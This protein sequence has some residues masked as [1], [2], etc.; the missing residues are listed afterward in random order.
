MR[1]LKKIA[2]FI[3]ALGMI[4]KKATVAFFGIVKK[5]NIEDMAIKASGTAVRWSSYYFL[6]WGIWFF[7]GV[8]VGILKYYKAPEVATFLTLW[9]V[10]I[11]LAIV[12]IVICN[13]TKKD[14]TLGEAIRNS[15]NAVWSESR[16]VGA[17]VFIG[18]MIKFIFWDGSDRVLIFFNKE[19][20]TFEKK[21]FLLVAFAGVKAYIYAKLFILGYDGVTKLLF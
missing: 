8:I 11:T 18:L 14:I 17:L 10:E 19:I 4:L 9:I 13:E 16:I 5:D 6:D 3:A 1:Y 7:M 20:T 15:F 12:I 2:A 21:A